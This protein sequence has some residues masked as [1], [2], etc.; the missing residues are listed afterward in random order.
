MQKKCIAIVVIDVIIC[1][2]IMFRFKKNNNNTN[3]LVTAQVHNIEFAGGVFQW[4]G[5]L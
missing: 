5:P 2:C 4:D 3:S 1:S